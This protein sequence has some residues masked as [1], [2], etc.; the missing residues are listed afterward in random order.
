[1]RYINFKDND[2]ILSIINSDNAFNYPICNKILLA[3]HHSSLAKDLYDQFDRCHDSKHMKE[4]RDTTFELTGYDMI[5]YLCIIAAIYHDIGRIG[6]EKNHASIGADMYMSHFL[7]TDNRESSKDAYN[8]AMIVSQLILTHS[9]FSDHI[10]IEDDD[11]L[12]EYRYIIMDADKISHTNLHRG[13]ERILW[14][15]VDKI[16]PEDTDYESE[17]YI[18]KMIDDR[19]ERFNGKLTFEPKSEAAKKLIG[20]H[21]YDIS[22][23]IIREVYN[24]MIL[25][26]LIGDRS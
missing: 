16:C 15:Y 7:R 6:G 18:K 12:K 22:E 20:F 4:V 19:I 14:Y 17:E 24:T 8:H 11:P 3:D 21:E 13:I 9:S 23:D 26:K 10:D 25:P 2:A 5:D 1:V